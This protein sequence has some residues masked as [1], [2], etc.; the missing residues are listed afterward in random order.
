MEAGTAKSVGYGLDKSKFKCWQ[1]QS[2]QTGCGAR[3]ASYS[4]VKGVLY[5][6]VV[7]LSTS[8]HLAAGTDTPVFLIMPSRYPGPSYSRRDTQTVF[9]YVKDNGTLSSLQKQQQVKFAY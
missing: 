9:S 4:V 1:G 2:V 3:P 8:P 7:T 5:K 6:G